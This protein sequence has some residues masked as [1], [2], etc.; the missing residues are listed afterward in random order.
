MA[1]VDVY[2]ALRSKRVYKDAFSHERSL[3][4]I[5]EESGKAFDPEIVEAFLEVADEIEKIFA[6]YEKPE[7]NI[8]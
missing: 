4:I 7:A 5:K 2:Y 8:S 6:Q 3:A 1:I